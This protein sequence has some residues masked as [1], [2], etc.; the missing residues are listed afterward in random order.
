VNGTAEHA[1]WLTVRAQVRAWLQQRLPAILD[2]P[3]VLPPAADEPAVAA[4]DWPDLATLLTEYPA[5]LAPALRK[6]RGAWYTPHALAVATAQRT[7]APLLQDGP[8][9]LRIVDPAVGGGAFLLAAFE[10]LTAAGWSPRDAAACLHGVDLDDTIA[11]TTALALWQRSGA[12]TDDLA[13]LLAN[14]C[15]GDGLRDLADGTFDA[16]LGNPPW[17]T[18]QGEGHDAEERA[19]LRSRFVH[20]GK[21][22]RYTYRL[23]L[24]R[25][26]RLLRDRGRFGLLVPASLWFD[27]DARQLR[28]LLLDT[29][30]WEWLY[31]FEN[32]HCEFAI[33]P[34][35]RYAALVGARGGRTT[36]VR[37]AFGRLHTSDWTT[38]EP[39]HVP[40][41]RRLF[42]QLSP[43]SR[44][45]VE[46]DEPRDLAILEQVV[47]GGRA[48]L[49]PST[50]QWR[51]GDHNMTSHRHRFVPLP[52]AEAAGFVLGDDGLWR[53]GDRVLAPLYQGAMLDDLHPYTGTYAGGAGRATRWAPPASLAELRPQYLVAPLAKAPWPARIGVRAL[54]N[55]SNARTTVACLLPPVPCGNSL[56]LLTPMTKSREPLRQLAS[57]AAIL[58][59]LPFDWQLRLRLTGTNLNRFVLADCV[60][61][62]I[63][64]RV[65][66]ELARLALR[67][68][69]ILPWHG[70]LWQ[71]AL[72]EGWGPATPD[73]ALD[74]DERDRLH[75]RIDT[76][77][78]SAY[79]MTADDVAWIVRGCDRP[80]HSLTPGRT[81]DLP[82]RGFWRV[83]RQQPPPERRP[84]RWLAAANRSAPR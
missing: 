19:A 35:Y 48:L 71:H 76:L 34:R 60:L 53:S 78:G 2:R 50:F 33:D 11:T 80:S 65:R 29:C 20:Q 31:G 62:A 56:V 32:R 75:T 61:P 54:S 74:R 63:S 24:E 23:F 66:N 4:G 39:T 26:V 83:D 70:A 64:P 22:K 30:T 68:C 6:R 14:V 44:A 81:A 36:A 40:Y 45:F 13:P 79:G 15:R 8:R 47:A 12:A 82:T 37:V 69:A 3:E 67:L 10:V 77:V 18:L 41:P 16:V 58:A 46:V 57:T 73:P 1:R 72:R 84:M 21:G 9:P 52:E 55:A 49:S 51:Q 5:L 28:E 42:D 43:G 25:S 59:S 17:E 7:L 27:R 38:A